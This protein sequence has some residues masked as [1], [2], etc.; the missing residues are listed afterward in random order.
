[1]TNP[2]HF[3]DGLG[4]DANYL[5]TVPNAEHTMATGLKTMLAGIA[6][7]VT[8][9]TARMLPPTVA[10]TLLPGKGSRSLV[11]RAS[12]KPSRVTL[13]RATTTAGGT[14]LRRDF[15]MLRRR[16][17]ETPCAVPV[18]DD[19]CLNPLVWVEADV[20]HLAEPVT[21][22]ATGLEVWEVHHNEPAPAQEGLY[23]GFFL[24]FQFPGLPL[25]PGGPAAT[26]APSRATSH[27]GVVPDTF[28][29][30]PCAG[31][32]ACKGELV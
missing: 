2:A 17:P 23:R 28:P 3:F 30:Q 21:D 15:R 9:L 10:S 1:M 20:T 32:E 22:E 6:G 24:E 27:V 7:F 18:S 8:A 14:P 4:G 5:L 12:A 19:L 13:W 29:F 26:T 16:L 31:G 25:P 11:A